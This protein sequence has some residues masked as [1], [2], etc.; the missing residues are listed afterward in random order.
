MTDIIPHYDSITYSAVAGCILTLSIIY[1]LYAVDAKRS[2]FIVSC[3]A[4]LLSD[5]LSHVMAENIANNHTEPIGIFAF[6]TH[7]LTQLIIVFIFIYSKN[8]EWGIRITTIFSIVTTGFWIMYQHN[9]TAYT[10]ASLGAILLITYFIYLIEKS[11]GT[12]R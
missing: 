1:G 8:V 3:L 5:P 10:A 11:I 4:V 12:H 2:S 7:L 6:F 9:N